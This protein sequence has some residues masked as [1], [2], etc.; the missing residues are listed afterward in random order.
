MGLPISANNRNLG[1]VFH[2][3]SFDREEIWKLSGN[4][5]KL[6]ILIIKVE[7]RKHTT[8][9]QFNIIRVQ[10]LNYIFN[11]NNTITLLISDRIV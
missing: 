10:R 6:L 1:G 8:P 3:K 7:I 9:R 11:F 2:Y 4:C 5:Y